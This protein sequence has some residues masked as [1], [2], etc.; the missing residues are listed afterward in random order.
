MKQ[1]AIIE[2]Y[3]KTVDA[4]AAFEGA[5]MAMI[6]LMPDSPP[7]ADGKTHKMITPD[8]HDCMT[9]WRFHLQDARLRL[10]AVFV[11]MLR[12]SEEFVEQQLAEQAAGAAAPADPAPNFKPQDAQP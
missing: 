4:S 6:A 8:M 1:D 12:Y 2:A 11:D 3:K 7:D 5:A 10:N 9:G